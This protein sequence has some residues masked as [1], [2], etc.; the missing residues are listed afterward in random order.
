[1]RLVVQNLVEDFS[2]SL[3][4]A[5]LL[6]HLVL[7]CPTYFL[8]CCPASTCLPSLRLVLLL[9]LSLPCPPGQLGGVHFNSFRLTSPHLTSPHLTSP[10]FTSPHLTSPHLTSPYL[11]SPHL[12]SP[13]LASP[14]LFSLRAQ[15]V[16][17]TCH[18]RRLHVHHAC[19]AV[20]DQVTVD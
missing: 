10:H 14:H 20:C 4:I 15:H 9:F 7:S 1:M 16:P 11:T 3:M 2:K 18:T 12:T 13:H 8:P 19:A 5:S 17:Y 6:R